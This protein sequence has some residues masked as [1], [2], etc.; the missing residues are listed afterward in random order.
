VEEER[1]G[2][3]RRKRRSFAALSICLKINLSLS[4]VLSI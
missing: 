3:E 4:I 1:R 2:E